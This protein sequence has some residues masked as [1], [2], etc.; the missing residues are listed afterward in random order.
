MDTYEGRPGEPLTLHKYLYAHANPVMGVDP[1]G[2]LTLSELSF[3]WGIKAILARMAIGAV[4]GGVDAHLRGY[5]IM[6]G[7]IGGAVGGAI[8]PIVP[9]KLGLVFGVVGIAD[10]LWAGE[11][12]SAIFRVLTFGAGFIH[13]VKGFKSFVDFKKW[14]GKAGSGKAW[15]HIVEQNAKNVAKFGMKRIHSL[16]NLVRL[17][18]GKGLSHQKISGFYSSRQP[19]LTGSATKSVRDWVSE[20]SFFE[21]YIFGLQVMSRF[22]GRFGPESVFGW[23]VPWIFPAILQPFAGEDE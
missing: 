2:Y 18:H 6:E 19:R 9:L 16:L 11:W 13:Q 1:S 22:S 10:A 12:D 8:A 7:I 20:K 3:G 4:L 21:Q 14:F 15:H 17:P 5:D 23:G